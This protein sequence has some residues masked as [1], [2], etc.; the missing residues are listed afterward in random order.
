MEI[1]TPPI[2]PM[3]ENHDFGE[4]VAALAALSG[5]TQVQAAIQ[6]ASF[7]AS[8]AGPRGGLVRL[9]GEVQPIGSSV[10]S[11]G[12]ASPEQARL[13]ELLYSPLR[14]LQEDLI[15][16]SARVDPSLRDRLATKLADPHHTNYE[17]RQ[18]V[19]EEEL[20]EAER[21]HAATQ[22]GR[23]ERMVSTCHPFDRH[24]ELER[25]QARLR[26]RRETDGAFAGYSLFADVD[27]ETMLEYNEARCLREPIVLLENPDSQVLLRGIG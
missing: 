27:F 21:T 10:I 24:E 9:G 22:A 11:V 7:L 26:D 2:L 25:E 23:S 14:Y 12:G 20:E 15:D 4:A 16:Y 19:G 5:A 13:T 18:A 17:H 1:V 3:N 8:L 6:A